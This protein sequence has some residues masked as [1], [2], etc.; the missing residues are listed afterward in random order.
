MGGKL[1]SSSSNSFDW[2]KVATPAGLNA[3]SEEQR[4][5]IEAVISGNFNVQVNAVAG[6]GK[7]TTLLHVASLVPKEE[8]VLALL[9]SARLKDETREKAA[10]LSL[11]NLH[12]HSFHAFA[13]GHYDKRATKDDGLSLIVDADTTP[14][15][16]FAYDLIVI[17]EIQDLTPLLSDFVFKILRDNR[18]S[19]SV[20]LL[21]LGDDRQN[22]FA[23]KSADARYLTLS[24]SVFGRVNDLP[25]LKLPLKT[26]FRLT[27]NMA[28]FMNLNVLKYTLFEATKAPGPCVQYNR[29]NS[30]DVATVLAEELGGMLKS[31]EIKPED[32]FILGPSIKQGK[33]SRQ[34]PINNLANLLLG[35]GWPYYAPISEEQQLSDD[36]SRNKIVVST[37][38]QTKGLERK[39]VVIF[40]FCNS[41]FQYFARQED[42]RAVPNILYVA[43]TR[44]TER[45]ILVAED[46]EGNKLPFLNDV[47]ESSDHLEVRDVSRMRNG[48]IIHAKPSAVTVTRLCKFLP[49][50]LAALAASF[51]KTRQLV[52]PFQSPSLESHVETSPG[53]VEEVYELNGLAIPALFERR[54]TKQPSTIQE[55]ACFELTT[56]ISDERG[57]PSN[58][59]LS[60]LEETQ[61]TYGDSDVSA[62]L[63]LATIYSFTQS[64]FLSKPQ[65]IQKYDWIS[66]GQAEEC[67]KV[68]SSHLTGK[69]LYES[70]VDYTRR[71]PFPPL[72]DSPEDVK[73]DEESSAASV[74]IKGRIDAI[75]PDGILWELKCVNRLD[76]EH[77]LQLAVYAWIVLRQ[78]GVDVKRKK[79]RKPIKGYRLLNMRTGELLELVSSFEEIE[80]AV[81][82]LVE[83]H[84]KGDPKLTDE[85]FMSAIDTKAPKGEKGLGAVDVVV[86]VKKARKK[87]DDASQRESS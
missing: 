49:E 20:R 12:V 18:S 73:I 83:K 60:L 63:R 30:W 61:K 71:F 79:K 6:S 87:R 52:A 59:T 35:Q 78:G 86:T 26:T 43:C 62:H 68:L 45:L 16:S 15:R 32:I 72:P 85:Q 3:P 9:Y 54:M 70:S 22:I 74:S 10:G 76:P 67:I 11:T 75:T 55:E 44:A 53:L 84:L 80:S 81:S 13:V 56:S 5:V 29:G 42:P 39:I 8:K 77:L 21:V 4:A 2:S 38:H 14:V 25:W 17:D 40:G 19:R 23:F 28:S 34:T 37:F 64:G 50:N 27:K 51:L 58:I 57:V 24:P 48:E 1:F 46:V 65:L 82:L 36:S 31:R 7:T 33:A 47:D 69:V 66:L 41:Y